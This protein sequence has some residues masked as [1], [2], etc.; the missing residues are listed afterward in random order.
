MQ[1]RQSTLVAA[2]TNKC[3]KDCSFCLATGYMQLGSTDKETRKRAF[4]DIIDVNPQ[5]SNIAWSGGEPLLE[6]RL[7]RDM[8]ELAKSKRPDV[9]NVLFTNGMS[10]K[11][12]DLD[13]YKQMTRIH[14]SIDGFDNSE[15]NL[16]EFAKNNRY[17]AFEVLKELD[18]VM[19]KS[20]ITYSQL[21]NMR[22]Y[23]D[24]IQMHSNLHHLG[25]MT[26]GLALDHQSDVEM[27]IDQAIN[28]IYGHSMIDRNL[29]ELNQQ[30]KTNTDLFTEKMFLSETPCHCYGSIMANTDGTVTYDEEKETI[31]TSGCS[32][33]AKSLGL[34]TY[35]LLNSIFNV[36]FVG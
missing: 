9:T 34:E 8:F 2:I 29:V 30:N 10:M 35:K 24:I 32:V 33:L 27:T 25:I 15:R 23:E 7:L 13:L 19:V 6:P 14:L 5:V 16:T 26:F 18:N 21:D 36:P 3:D 4:S 20:V 11:L 1:R 22:W 31:I 17:E 28:M 12:K